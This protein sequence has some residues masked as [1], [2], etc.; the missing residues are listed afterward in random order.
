MVESMDTSRY[1]QGGGA[2]V[3]AANSAAQHARCDKQAFGIP[4]VDRPAALMVCELFVDEHL[5]K[6]FD[7]PRPRWCDCGAGI[8]NRSTCARLAAGFKGFN[9]Y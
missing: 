5:A 1:F 8:L 3:D 6:S 9:N 2:L 7:E 4:D